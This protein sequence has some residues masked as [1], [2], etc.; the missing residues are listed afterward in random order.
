MAY[1]DLDS[2]LS[3][4][5]LACLSAYSTFVKK[6]ERAPGALPIRIPK[7]QLRGVT[8]MSRQPLACALF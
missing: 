2:Y 7:G 3:P 8:R 6:A 4:R 1:G 5:S